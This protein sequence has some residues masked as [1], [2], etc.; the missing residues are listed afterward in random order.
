[1]EDNRDSRF[2]K[3]FVITLN[4]NGKEETIECVASLK[5]LR[6][7]NYE[8]VVVDNG[9]TDESVLALGAQYPDITVIANG[10]NLGYAAGFNRGL[11]YAYDNGAIYFLVINNDC[12]VDSEVLLELVKV[13]QQD[14]MIGFVS[15]KVYWYTKPNT[16]QT[17]GRHSDPVTLAGNHVGSGELDHGQHDTVQEYDFIDDVFLLV[18][19]QVYETVGGYDPNFFLYYEETDWCARVRKAGFKIMYTPHARIWHKG[20]IGGPSSALSPVRHY[21]L[22]R[23][24][25]IF[26]SRN[27][28]PARFRKFLFWSLRR[29][30]LDAARRVRHGHFRHVL[31]RLRGMGSGLVWVWQNRAGPRT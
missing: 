14:E 13:A 18:R 20:N 5:S 6:Y 19:R 22:C 30:T 17:A 3:V 10:Q 21:Y 27:S 4:W 1:M 2:P 12:V 23:N 8:I 24:E 16:L 25:I 31:A 7:P 28:S 9:S 26:M 29:E 15:G 11:R